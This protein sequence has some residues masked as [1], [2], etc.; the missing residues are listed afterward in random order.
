MKVSYDLAG[1]KE[2]DLITPC[3]A[4]IKSEY[5]ENEEYS[6]CSIDAYDA[7]DDGGSDLEGNIFPWQFVEQAQ[8]ESGFRTG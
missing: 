4:F 5:Y 1:G 8:D 2:C 6:A 3:Y 7:S